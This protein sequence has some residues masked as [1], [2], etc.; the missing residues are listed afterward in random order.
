[1]PKLADFDGIRTTSR[2]I[3]GRNT[4]RKILKICLS[5]FEDQS[6]NSSEKPTS[7]KIETETYKANPR[8]DAESGQDLKTL[9]P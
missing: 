5:V 9:P 3:L 1:M 4:I 8:L 2:S 6:I 7:E